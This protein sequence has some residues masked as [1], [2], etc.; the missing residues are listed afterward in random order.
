VREKG[1]VLNE[2]ECMVVESGW[3]QERVGGARIEWAEPRESGEP[4]PSDAEGAG[5]PSPP[6]SGYP[7]R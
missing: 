4:G 5:G 6:G 7:R 2:V 1:E 3:S